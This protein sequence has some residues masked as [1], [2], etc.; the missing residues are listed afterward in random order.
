MLT[1]EI[2]KA[3][4]PQ[5]NARVPGLVEGIVSSAPAVFTKYGLNNDLVV[6]HAMAQFSHE[7]GAGTEM[8][9]KIHYTADRACQVWDNRF[10]NPADCY[11]KVGSS[12]GDPDFYKKLINYVYGGRYG[13]RPG[14]DDGTTFI[15]RGLSQVTFRGNY[16]TLGK[17]LG[18]DL[19]G[20][21]EL[22]N[23]PA[24]ALE[25]G[26]ADFIQ[27]GCLPFAQADDVR[28]VTQKL[29]GGHE[30][31]DE[32]KAWLARWKAALASSGISMQ[33]AT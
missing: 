8:V 5:G 12:E 4:W 23:D 24:H 3:M 22:V 20:H 19:V 26:V 6:A 14:T 11:T 7:C 25:C 10:S 13:N 18:L 29:N 30:G 17:T 32:R 21:P 16:E 27:C 33:A 1:L 28:G 9:E 2:M 31:L 15:G